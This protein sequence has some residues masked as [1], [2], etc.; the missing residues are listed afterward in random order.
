VYEEVCD[1][2]YRKDHATVGKAYSMASVEFSG[3]HFCLE[4]VNRPTFNEG[5]GKI[6]ITRFGSQ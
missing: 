3:E 6:T 5:E 2:K 4:Y 1:G